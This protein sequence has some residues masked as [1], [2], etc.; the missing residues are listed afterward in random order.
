[1]GV[2]HYVLPPCNP[3]KTA[4]FPC[5]S[6]GVLL[7]G[8]ET[9]P[10]LICSG[11]LIGVLDGQGGVALG[12]KG[13]TPSHLG[14]SEGLG[15]VALGG[16]GDLAGLLASRG[17]V[18]LGGPA[19]ARGRPPGSGGVALGGL[20]E[21]PGRLGPI[22]TAGGAALGG[23]ASALKWSNPA[24]RTGNEQNFGSPP[25]SITVSANAGDLLIVWT[26]SRSTVGGGNRVPTITTAGYTLVEHLDNTVDVAVYVWWAQFATA[27]TTVAFSWSGSSG[28][29]Y[30]TGYMSFSGCPAASLD[31]INS[32]NGTSTAPAIST[33]TPLNNAV[34]VCV[35]VGGSNN[36]EFTS[37]FSGCSGNYGLGS[38]LSGI[39]AYKI[40]TNGTGFTTTAGTLLSKDWI[41]CSATFRI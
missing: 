33:G 24:I 2:N 1:M 40:V 13:S 9:D 39:G 18:S 32:S 7:G 19:D 5:S 28:N 11:G 36:G 14:P 35:V 8:S 26:T 41:V 25:A 23:S 21:Q 4:K 38:G 20:R 12:G 17:G 29:N 3:P 34:E 6:P 37:G 15:G 22:Q 16:I 27:Q 10:G 31:L 30:E